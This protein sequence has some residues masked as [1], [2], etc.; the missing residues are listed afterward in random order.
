M[1][2]KAKNKVSGKNSVHSSRGAFKGD[3]GDIEGRI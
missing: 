2:P 3:P 1:T